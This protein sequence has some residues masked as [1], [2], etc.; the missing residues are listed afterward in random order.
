MK[1]TILIILILFLSFLLYFYRSPRTKI[2]HNNFDI[3]Y[4]PAYGKIININKQEDKIYISIFLRALDVHYQY[5]PISGK[6]TDIKYDYTGKFNLAY[7]LNKSNQ[8]EKAI[9]TI[10]NKRGIF[11][12]H[13]IA[14]FFVRRISIFAVKGQQIQTGEKLGI[15]HLGSRVDI[16]IPIKDANKFEL[17]VEEGQQVCGTNTILGKYLV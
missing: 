7:E 4:S 11:E 8:N 14:G 12:V 5:A 3:I 1:K 6:I 10:E 13:Q 2:I 15:I 9:Y 17:Y 16:I